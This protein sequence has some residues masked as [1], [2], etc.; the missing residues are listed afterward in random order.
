MVQQV[1]VASQKASI[2]PPVK[3]VT[4]DSK[5]NGSITAI[6]QPKT[7]GKGT[8]RTLYKYSGKMPGKGDLQTP[9]MLA[10]VDTVNEATKTELDRA[11]F[12]AQDCVTLAVKKGFLSTRQNPLR[13]F[14]FYAKRLVD[15]GYFSKV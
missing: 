3:K 11:S 1:S 12:T 5:G 9:Q 8:V 13:I 2:K 7:T 10:L 4:S 6:P 14:R 15:E